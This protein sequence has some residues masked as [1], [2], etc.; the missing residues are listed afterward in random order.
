MLTTSEISKLNREAEPDKTYKVI[1][2]MRHGFAEHNELIEEYKKRIRDAPGAWSKL[3]G[4]SKMCNRE[5]ISK[6]FTSDPPLTE[7][8]VQQAEQLN[9][10]LRA[11]IQSGMPPPEDV[12][13]ST[14]DRSLCTTVIGL[15]RTCAGVTHIQV[16]PHLS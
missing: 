5:T 8:G 7:L 2:A 4:F 6:I 16:I 12:Y 13:A 11:Q 10:R 15:K 9:E 1:Y 14:L 3:M